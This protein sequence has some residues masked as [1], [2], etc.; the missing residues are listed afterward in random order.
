MEARL[1]LQGPSS[2][3]TPLPSFI[4]VRA[5][6]GASVAYP[7]NPRAQKFLGLI[8]LTS[9]ANLCLWILL[10]TVGPCLD[11][12]QTSHESTHSETS[13]QRSQRR[14]VRVLFGRESTILHQHA[15]SAHNR[16]LQ[17]EFETCLTFLPRTY[18]IHCVAH[19]E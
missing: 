3:T 13:A 15:L 12:T 2:G 9:M 6:V 10:D 16:F 14:W 5:I 11:T 4:E 17:F 7:G 8:D 1:S 18:N 19:R